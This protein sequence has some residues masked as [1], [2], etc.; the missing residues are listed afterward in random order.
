[1]ADV[2]VPRLTRLRTMLPQGRA[3]PEGVWR[4][5]HRGI[6]ALLWA[7]AVFIPAYGVARGYPVGHLILESL[8]VPTAG[9]LAGSALLERRIRTAVASLGLLTSSAVLVHLSGGLIEMHFHFFVMVSVV[10]LYQDWLPF[11]TAIAY[12][13]VHHGLMGTL[14][15]DSVYNHTS[16]IEHP[17]RWA[18]VH[19]AFITGS[20]I[21]CLVTWRLNERI[22][23]HNEA[24][25]ESEREARLASEVA[26]SGLHLLADATRAL[27]SSLEVNVILRSL[28]SLVTRSIADY[29]ILDIVNDDGTIRRVA[30]AGPVAAGRAAVLEAEPPSR[31]D[32]DNPVLR[33]IRTGRPVLLNPVPTEFVARRRNRPSE[34]T[35]AHTSAIIAPLVGRTATLGALTIVCT[36][37][38]RALGESELH[39]A[40]ELGRR[41]GIAIENARLFAR[42]RTVA[43]T[44]QHSL[45]PEQLPDVP[46]VEAAARY[47]A[48]GPGVEVGGDWYDVIRLSRGRLLLVMGDVVGRGER[49]AALM[50]QVRNALRAYALFDIPPATVVSHVNRLMHDLDHSDMATMVCALLDPETGEMSV[51]NAGH[52]A[53]ALLG[54]DGT[55]CFLDHVSGPPVGAVLRTTYRDEVCTIEPGT[56][57]LM[58]TDGLVEDRETP[59]D[60]GMTALEEALRIAPA[61]VA[62][63]VDHVL[64]RGLGGRSAGDDVAILAVRLVAL[65]DHLHLELPTTLASLESL[66]STLRRW[67]VRAGA[68][69]EESFEIVVAACEACANVIIHARGPQE[70]RF[71]FDA[72]RDGD[73]RIEVRDH[74]RWRAP[75]QDSGGRG[76]HIMESFMDEVRIDKRSDGTHVHMRRRLGALAD[77]H[78]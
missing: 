3:L 14:D 47:V 29:C 49:A 38:R 13:V 17:W 64:Q 20:S 73:I 36:S 58:Y 4:G 7:N 16:A 69:E 60:V 70:N 19:G 32:R 10:A 68:T 46:G 55:V 28:A 66:R 26:Q 48:G 61:D 9:V 11:L 35:L 62:G 39:L 37:E 76:L 22:Q 6:L 2:K 77:S 27:T 33:C 53:V 65:D 34:A 12:V 23:A 44:L 59:L 52:P 67:L 54:P 57:I 25:Y 15:S 41:A 5:R 24:L 18:G 8:L 78:S 42:Q 63:L 30:A 31:G 45:L 74:G 1:M 51:A 75:R 21:A 40:S 50:G 43:E 71:E 72:R 56:T